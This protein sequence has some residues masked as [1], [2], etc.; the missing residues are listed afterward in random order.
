[1]IQAEKVPVT[2]Y[3][4]AA[5][6]AFSVAGILS[7]PKSVLAK[8]LS[9]SHAKVGAASI[10]LGLLTISTSVYKSL[11]SQNSDKEKAKW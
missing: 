10:L 7:I 2:G 1:L 6:M 5:V 11:F 3:I 4:N 8:Q 9:T